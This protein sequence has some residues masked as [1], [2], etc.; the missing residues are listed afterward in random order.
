MTTIAAYGYY[1]PELGT[2]EN[3]SVLCAWTAFGIAL[4]ALVFAMGLGGDLAS[5]MALAG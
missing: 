2:Q 3:F 1:A 5:S 4:T